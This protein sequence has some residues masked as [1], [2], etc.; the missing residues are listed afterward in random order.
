MIDLDCMRTNEQTAHT[1]HI[2]IAEL[3][4][5]CESAQKCVARYE[6]R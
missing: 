4:R 5:N 2:E 6:S 1:T 3:G